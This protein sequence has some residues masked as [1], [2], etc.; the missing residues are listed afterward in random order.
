LRGQHLSEV[1]RRPRGTTNTPMA[2]A[3]RIHRAPRRLAQAF[4][5]TLCVVPQLAA[6]APA[7]AAAPSATTGPALSLTSSSANVTGTVNP[8][9]ESTTYSFQFGTTTAYG[10]QTNPQSAGSGT[11][12][13][14]V[15]ATLTGLRPATTYH[16]R[17]IATNP[18]GTTV[19]VDATFTTLGVPP[20]PPGP[21]PTATTRSAIS[22]GT[23]RATVR[24]T[25][26]PRRER[27]TYYFEFG[28]SAAYGAQTRQRSLSA[29]TS[30]RSVRATLTGLRPGQTYH[31]RLVA[32]N[33]NGEGLGADRT[34]TTATPSPVRARPTLTARVVP[35]RDRRRPFRFRVRGTLIPPAGIDRSRACRG[36]VAIRFKARSRTVRLRR[37]RVRRTCRYR[38]RV[39]VRVR[40]RVLRVKVRFRG[41]AV[42]RPKS[43]P[44]RRVRAG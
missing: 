22:I 20:P 15:S 14:A 26:N 2:V 21:P 30:A 29:G 19:G 5:F 16:Y 37:A 3:N 35:R 44:T 9:G 10:S 11:E 40:P 4:L 42:L 38:A 41:N 43:A 12:N 18:S 33:V 7:I 24:G 27:T 39:L 8:N 13:Q 23:T 36:R 31:Y 28:L 25:V 6:S 17:L 34:F 1:S 32:K